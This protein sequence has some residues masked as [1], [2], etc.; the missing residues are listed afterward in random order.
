MLSNSRAKPFF[1][2]RSRAGA[3]I[4]ECNNIRVCC[5]VKP[6]V[7]PANNTDRLCLSVPEVERDSRHNAKCSSSKDKKTP[8][9]NGSPSKSE[10]QRTSWS[11]LSVGPN[12]SELVVYHGHVFFFCTSICDF[13]F[14]FCNI[15]RMVFFPISGSES[16]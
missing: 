10:H 5:R 9:K 15:L 16:E 7:S 3:A 11:R 12:E 4:V 14:L 13:I 6:V 1:P 8:S 2:P